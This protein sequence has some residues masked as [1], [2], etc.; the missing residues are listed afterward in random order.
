MAYTAVKNNFFIIKWYLS[1]ENG[2]WFKRNDSTDGKGSPSKGYEKRYQEKAKDH[3]RRIIK[4]RT[5]FSDTLPEKVNEQVTKT[6]S[7]NR[8][9]EGL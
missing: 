4:N 7:R 5:R 6:E 1:P 8:K 3:D 9:K 2:S